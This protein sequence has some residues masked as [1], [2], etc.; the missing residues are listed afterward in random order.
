[1]SH[2]PP[3]AQKIA[4]S[5]AFA[6]L[7]AFLPLLINTLIEFSNTGDWAVWKALVFS[8]IAGAVAAGVRAIVAYLPIFPDDNVGITKADVKDGP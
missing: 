4:R 2:F 1:M 5:F 6:F 8:G 3:V 7:G